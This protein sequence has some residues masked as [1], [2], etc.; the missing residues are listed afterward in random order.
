MTAMEFGIH[1]RRRV[2]KTRLEASIEPLRADPSTR[3][4]IRS[5]YPPRR[6]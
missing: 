6:R 2:Y 4:I 5:R 1:E 3:E